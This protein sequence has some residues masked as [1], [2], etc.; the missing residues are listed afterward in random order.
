M[1]FQ[2]VK[3]KV[4]RRPQH[5]YTISREIET[6]QPSTQGYLILPGTLIFSWA[7]LTRLE[8]NIILIMQ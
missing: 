6:G 7:I 3:D 2:G 5:I 8:K 1:T 4:N